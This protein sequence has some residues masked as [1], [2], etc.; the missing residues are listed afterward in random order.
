MSAVQL[1]ERFSR[2]ANDK[3][4]GH[5]LIKICPLDLAISPLLFLEQDSQYLNR[6]VEIQLIR[7]EPAFHARHADTWLLDVS[8]FMQ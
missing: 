8:M 2:L 3:F 4:I 7:A 1:R 6:R 5:E